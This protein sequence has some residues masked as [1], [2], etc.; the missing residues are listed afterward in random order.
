MDVMTMTKNTQNTQKFVMNAGLFGAVGTLWA[1]TPGSISPFLYG[2]KTAPGTDEKAA[3][4]TAGICDAN[5][6]ILPH[7]K[8]VLEVLGTAR[9]F[10]RMYLSGNLPPSECIVY[11]SPDGSA[12]SLMNTGSDMEIIF[13]AAAAVFVEMAVQGIG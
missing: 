8:P 3:L 4:V 11:F 13:P 5:G 2:T 7:A 9:A 10:T 6:Q 12:V 1:G